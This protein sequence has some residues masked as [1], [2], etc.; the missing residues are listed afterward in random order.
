MPSRAEQLVSGP[1]VITSDHQHPENEEWWRGG[2]GGEGSGIILLGE[3]EAGECGI[4]LMS[5][6]N[7]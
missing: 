5:S 1:I 6:M 2:R 3:R 7:Y 4:V